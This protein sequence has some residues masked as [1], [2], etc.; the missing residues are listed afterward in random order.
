[1]KGNSICKAGFGQI[2]RSSGTGKSHLGHL[3]H[4]AFDFWASLCHLFGEFLPFG[5]LIS[6]PF[7]LFAM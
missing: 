2:H 1:M 5:F 4:L 6:L 7:V 3:C